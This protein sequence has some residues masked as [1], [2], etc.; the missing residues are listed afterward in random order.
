MTEHRD[1]SKPEPGHWLVRLVKNGPRIPAAIVRHCTIMEPGNPLN[2]MDRSG[3]LVG[4][5]NGEIVD[6]GRVWEMRGEPISEAEYAFRCRDAAWAKEFA[7]DE[8]AANANRPI[9][10]L[11]CKPPL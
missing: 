3:F 7:A 2:K 10:Y 6:P 1:I 8:P 9:D 11:A 5:I 4:Y